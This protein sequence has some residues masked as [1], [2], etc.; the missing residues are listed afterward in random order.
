MEYGSTELIVEEREAERQL[1]MDI[2]DS[3]K[4]LGEYGPLFHIYYYFYYCLHMIWRR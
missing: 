1:D 2:V 4:Y 3:F